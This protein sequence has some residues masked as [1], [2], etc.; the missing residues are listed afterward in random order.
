MEVVGR[1]AAVGQAGKGKEEQ[2][3]CRPCSPPDC[4][5]PF[6][7]HQT[8]PEGHWALPDGP[9]LG[10][11]AIWAHITSPSL[12]PSLHQVLHLLTSCPTSS[13]SLYLKR[14]ELLDSWRSGGVRGPN[15]VVP[16]RCLISQRFPHVG[17]SPLSV[18]TCAL[19]QLPFCGLLWPLS[20]PSLLSSL[21]HPQPHPNNHVS[22]PLNTSAFHPLRLG[23]C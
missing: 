7:R 6:S 16:W 13:I 22:P 11:G 21:T 17:I 15:A 4:L 10:H 2:Q 20:H 1:G 3:R 18:I 19:D 8:S 9:S 14:G 12:I 5:A 23:L